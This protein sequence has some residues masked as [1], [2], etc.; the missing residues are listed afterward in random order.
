[1]VE[2]SGACRIFSFV[3][4]ARIGDCEAIPSI[5]DEHSLLMLVT[6]R[7]RIILIAIPCVFLLP[8]QDGVFCFSRIILDEFN[9]LFP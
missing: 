3:H 9:T 6:A 8:V 2:E 7:H 1:M 4:F 5:P